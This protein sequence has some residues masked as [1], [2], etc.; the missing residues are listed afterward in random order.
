M[1]GIQ[2]VVKVI[3]RIAMMRALNTWKAFIGE[4]SLGDKVRFTRHV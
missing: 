1:S 4:K 2:V 3:V